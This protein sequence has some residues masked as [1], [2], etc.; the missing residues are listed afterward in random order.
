MPK[1][2]ALILAAGQSARAGGDTP[3]QYR[4]IAGQ[5]VLRHGLRTFLAH[6]GIDACCVVINPADRNLYDAAV[7]RLPLLAPVD[8][9]ETRQDS[10]RRGLESLAG[11]SFDRVLVHDAAR[12]FAGTGIIDAVIDALAQHRGVVPV[13]P[14]T[15]TLKRIGNPSNGDVGGNTVLETVDRSSLVQVQ[16]PQGFDY[17]IL[18]ATHRRHAGANYSDDAA[19]LE[20]EGIPVAAVPGGWENLKL[21]HAEDFVRAERRHF[22]AMAVRCSTGFDVH[23]FGS[24]D[25]VTLCG[26]AIPCDAALIGHSDADVALHAL[27][28]AIFG[29]IGAGDIGQHFP[30]GDE[31]WKDAPSSQFVA[32]ALSL[33][34]EHG[35]FI[36][37]VDL[38]IIG[39]QPKIT[40][41]REKMVAALSELLEI[42]AANIGLKATTTEGLGFTGRGEGLAAQAIV[43]LRTPRA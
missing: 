18:L 23:R 26:V 25:S 31:R 8:G 6:P 11:E 41:H 34:A 40:P 15:D 14:V 13:L 30:P 4:P 33:V 21:T 12:P 10:A 22:G 39:E 5:T 42:P 3:K 7:A 38:S 43:T 36:E 27:A 9:G 28:D 35:G 29:A 1:T 24:G 37:H 2:L 20:A 32:H 16:T 19:L 17:E